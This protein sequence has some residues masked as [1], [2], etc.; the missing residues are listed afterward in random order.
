[1]KQPATKR[2]RL[3]DQ[4][5]VEVS[6][7][8]LCLNGFFVELQP[9]FAE[10]E[11]I[12]RRIRTDG[13]WADAFLL[14]DAGRWCIVSSPWSTQAKAWSSC[15]GGS[16]IN[17]WDASGWQQEDGQELSV[18]A[19]ALSDLSKDARK[20]AKAVF[21][22]PLKLTPFRSACEYCP[23]L[24]GNTK[25]SDWGLDSEASLY[26]HVC[27][28]HRGSSQ[29]YDM[30]R[31]YWDEVTAEHV[32]GREGE[33]DLF[34]QFE[35]FMHKHEYEKKTTTHTVG[36]H[37]KNL[38]YIVDNL[39]VQLTRQLAEDPESFEEI[40]TWQKE[41]TSKGHLSTSL[42]WFKKF[43]EVSV[44]EE[45]LAARDEDFEPDAVTEMQRKV[46]TMSTPETG[47]KGTVADVPPAK[48]AKMAKSQSEEV[49]ATGD[50]DLEPEAVAA[51]IKVDRK[52][53]GQA[54]RSKR[55]SVGEKW[56]G[57]LDLSHAAPV[58]R[59][60]VAADPY[61]AILQLQDRVSQPRQSTS[62]P[63]VQTCTREPQEPE[64]AALAEFFGLVAS[65][66]RKVAES[67]AAWEEKTG[68]CK[69]ALAQDGSTAG[70]LASMGEEDL[71]H[72]WLWA[73]CG[74]RDR[75]VLLKSLAALSPERFIIKLLSVAKSPNKA[76][77]DVLH[78]MTDV[79]G[80]AGEE[81]I[82]FKLLEKSAQKLFKCSN[83]SSFLNNPKLPWSTKLAVFGAVLGEYMA[84]WP[85]A[86][87]DISTWWVSFSKHV[88][89]LPLQLW[90]FAVSFAS[91]FCWN[92]NEKEAHQQL[93]GLNSSSSG[94]LRSDFE[95]LQQHAFRQAETMRGGSLPQRPPQEV[96]EAAPQEVQKQFSELQASP[97]QAQDLHAVEET[98]QLTAE[99]LKRIEQNKLAAMA[100]KRL[101][102]ERERAGSAQAGT[103]E[104][105]PRP[106]ATPMLEAAPAVP[107]AQNAQV[108]QAVRDIGTG[109]ATSIKVTVDRRCDH[110]TG[111]GF[112]IRVKDATGSIDLKFFGESADAFRANDALFPGAHVRLRGFRVCELSKDQIHFAPPGR[113][114]DLRCDP[115][116]FLIEKLQEPT[117]R[118]ASQ[119]LELQ[120]A[121]SKAND[122]RVNISSAWVREVGDLEWKETK[123]GKTM[124][125]RV[126]WL[127]S[128]KAGVD[129]IR[130]TLWNAPAEQYGEKQLL[131]Q[132]V[133]IHGAKVKHFRNNQEL[134]GCWRDGGI[135]I[136]PS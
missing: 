1:M 67:L 89:E 122:E 37:V 130:W 116:R 118:S 57:L 12:Y 121:V 107:A 59:V 87:E 68:P 105:G 79:I 132:R 11:P 93:L 28:F 20:E 69:E 111:G 97:L 95:H 52:V 2:K 100:K 113:K 53:S 10:K 23:K 21:R 94:S 50:E 60:A 126:I 88:A 135:E 72:A 5:V 91:G 75:T 43:V 15:E 128:S 77:I 36:K 25:A 40:K 119:A 109:T 103:S 8:H 30:H 99:Q 4:T 131:Q 80:A 81:R 66:D 73:Y 123:T 106:V 64:P 101:R 84:S 54:K 129:R 14:L 133:A 65:G 33:Q 29:Y 83:A 41:I 117:S 82:T 56:K 78:C 35:R 27:L 61:A 39:S 114:H 16:A 7:A 58:R 18:A 102:Q 125:L 86:A 96:H 51:D 46:S 98:S 115:K 70:D 112:H 48:R 19:R 44:V 47:C 45:V 127:A 120:E 26:A 55:R 22:E 76:P 32:L 13:S 134:T 38:Q 110:R 42:R 90:Y 85:S 104:L 6:G 63:R 71:E 17:V 49:L 92:Y 136:C 124:A 108:D 24:C 9:G 31:K 34:H 74:V 62:A 3:H